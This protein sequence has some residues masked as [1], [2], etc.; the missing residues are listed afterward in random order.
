MTDTTLTEPTETEEGHSWYRTWL[1]RLAGGTVVVAA[2]WFGS[3]W[4]FSST[5][6]F[7]LTLIL[8]VFIALA[9]LPGVERLTKRGWKRGAAAGFVMFVFLL[10]AIVFVAAM[11]SLVI[12]QISQ[13]IERLPEYADRVTV[14]VNDTFS[15]ELD[16]SGFLEEIESDEARMEEL[17]DNIL[18]SVL[19]LAGSV[20]GVVFQA[21]TIGLFVFYMLADLPR[22]RGAVLSRFP[23]KQQ[24]YIDTIFDISID[25][26]GG[27]V[28]SRAILAF[29]SSVYHFVVFVALDLPYPLAMALWV[30][31]VSQFVPTVGTYL[32]G[33]VPVVVA[34]L[35]D[36]NDALW[37]LIA[38]VVYQQIE[39]YLISPRVTANTMDLHPAVAFGAA[40][41]GANLLGGIG[42]LMALP[43]AAAVTALVQ[44]Y[45][46]HYDLVH[47]ENIE[48]QEEYEARMQAKADEKV[49]KGRWT[50]R[51]LR[52]NR[53]K[54]DEQG[55]DE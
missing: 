46:S 33:V 38:I 12:G 27:W 43:F 41:V 28:Y 39:N 18:G 25:K 6:D 2:F 45:T 48:S 22:L 34:L 35:E 37:V 44:T 52:R 3:I 55:D 16:V 26:V 7:L 5:T 11:A 29:F 53:S 10:I 20:V 17:R 32:A 51:M 36:P 42:A 4:V 50:D 54:G 49:G 40:I 23:Q 30:G 24:Q 14:W 15:V 21:L 13:L 9:L 1:P 31:V 47:S 19:G 8:S